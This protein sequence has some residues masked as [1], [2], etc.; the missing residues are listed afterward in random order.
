MTLISTRHYTP[1][2]GPTR[3]KSP[4]PKDAERITHYIQAPPRGI[5]LNSLLSFSYLTP[6][7]PKNP[8]PSPLHFTSPQ[9][10]LLTLRKPHST[11]NTRIRRHAAMRTRPSLTR[12]LIPLIR[13]RTRRS[14]CRRWCWCCCRSSAISRTSTAISKNTT[15]LVCSRTCSAYASGAGTGLAV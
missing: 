13:T 6:Q 7:P 2:A 15:A 8:T 12:A 5:D 3:S 14:W 10:T 4:K 11:I 1:K 9:E